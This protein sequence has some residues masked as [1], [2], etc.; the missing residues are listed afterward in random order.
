MKLPK[1]VRD[2]PVTDYQA[3]LLIF[4]SRNPDVSPYEIAEWIDRGLGGL[5]GRSTAHM[6]KEIKRLAELGYL[7]SDGPEIRPRGRAPKTKYRIN[8]QGNEAIHD[9]LNTTGAVLPA[10]DDSELSTRIRGLHVASPEVVWKGLRD[11][12]FQID[13]RRGLLDDHE[14]VLRRKTHGRDTGRSM[15]DC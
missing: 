8:K 14:R 2:S 6:Y 12:V 10:T 3:A 7:E 15:T 1:A 13:D 9:W 11:V 4:V 5:L